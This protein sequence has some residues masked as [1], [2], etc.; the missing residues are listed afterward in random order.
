[1]KS[2]KQILIEESKDLKPVVMAFGRMNPP[3]TGHEKL[4]SK[5]KEIAANHNAP[6]HV[7]L[8]QTQ[9]KKK[10]PLSAEQKLKHAKR[11]FPNTNISV[12]TKEH[13]TFIQHAA[14]LNAAGHKHLIMVA[15]S[16]RIGEYHD[17][18]H[19]YNGTH[20]G[21]LFNFKKIEV[22]SAGHRDP[23]AEGTE[24][25][26]ASKMRSHAQAGE[27][28][29]F[30]TGLPDHM[31]DAHKKELY[32]DVRSGM[33]IHESRDYGLFK[34]IFIT[35]GPGSGK[36]III[37][38]SISTIDAVELDSVQ[39]LSFLTDKKKIS[40]SFNAKK[41]SLHNK[42]TLIIN[43]SAANDHTLNL[44]LQLE[45]LGY[46]TMMIF[47][48]TTNEVSEKRNSGLSRMMSEETRY[49]KWKLSQ[50]NSLIFKENFELYIEFDNS[51]GIDEYESDDFEAISTIVESFLQKP[52]ESDVGIKWLNNQLRRSI[53]DSHIQNFFENFEIKHDVS[54]K[55]KDM[56]RQNIAR[57]RDKKRK[58]AETSNNSI[59]KMRDSLKNEENNAKETSKSIQ[60]ETP[61]VSEGGGN[62]RAAGKGSSSSCGKHTL[63]D[64][65]CPSCQLTG[66]EFMAKKP[67]V[68]DTDSSGPKT[69]LSQIF[70]TESSAKASSKASGEKAR[71]TRT[72][73]QTSPT[74]E[75]RP[76][77]K[78]PNF[79]QD[80]DKIKRKNVKYTSNSPSPYGNVKGTGIGPEYDT[81]GQGTV[82]PMSGIGQSISAGYEP[83][84]FG[85]FI[86]EMRKI[87]EAVDSP[88]TE[89]GVTGGQYGASNKDE[90][91][92]IGMKVQTAMGPEGKKKRS[93]FSKDKDVEKEIKNS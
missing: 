22:K 55:R 2:F 57:M 76:P 88:S 6:H 34:A 32:R 89:M 13:P 49:N 72:E 71:K 18:L 5:V 35:G 3:T 29:H 1:M 23:D 40:E 46:S 53:A 9:D 86:R 28:H 84:V 75:I 14:K 61:T 50:D 51:F 58:D 31:S 91:Q 27:Y 44:K 70:G 60:N 52:V 37:R 92:T 43:S 80:K 16:D 8:S 36:D 79:S 63:F 10:N 47:V 73:E 7:I 25:M 68:K 74:I 87:K 11:A 48:N 85:D 26:S 83:K 20:E 93:N 24:G 39:L 4:V 81:R 69:N 42:K 45:E 77:A 30:K 12:A 62:S 78:E 66:M 67:S 33:G 82:Y 41:E 19:K 17:L 54:Q 15:G 38:E 64:N 65:L 21:A 59:N 56:I 90:L